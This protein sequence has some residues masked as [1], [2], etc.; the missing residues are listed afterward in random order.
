MPETEATPTDLIL[1]QVEYYMSD[2]SYPFDDH[3]RSLQREADGCVPLAELVK[4]PRLAK[5]T[6]G[7]VE[8]LASALAG[9]DS[10]TLAEAKDGIKRNHP[11]PDDDPDATKTVHVAGFPKGSSDEAIK[12]ALTKHGPVASVRLLRNL[13]QDTRMLDGSAIVVFETD[14]AAAAAAAAGSNGMTAHAGS[15]ITTKALPEWFGK[16]KKEKERRDKIKAQGGDV[17]GAGPKKGDDAEDGSAKK[18]KR[19][20]DAP[21]EPLPPLKFDTI[22]GAVLAIEGLT[23]GASREDLNTLFE[24]FGEIKYT[25][26]SR[27][28]PTAHVRFA[29]AGIATTAAAACAVEGGAKELHGATLKCRAL[30]GDE[31]KAYWEKVKEAIESRRQAQHKTKGRG[32]GGGRG[33]WNKRRK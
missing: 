2:H 25:D 7:D 3:L 11:M 1:R 20:R 8:K 18:R 16:I 26:Y 32:R 21:I 31:E 22:D 9:S 33:G 27:G 17:Q 5:L 13:N 30:E 23:D 6:G 29:E 19:D 28:E 4:F 15:M 24:G 12:A 14:E 10:V